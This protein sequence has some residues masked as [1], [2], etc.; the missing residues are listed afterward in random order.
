MGNIIVEKLQSIGAKLEYIRILSCSETGFTARLLFR[1]IGA[2]AF[3]TENHL[4][5][6][7]RLV[8]MG[9]NDGGR[10]SVDIGC[11]W[12]QLPMYQNVSVLPNQAVY[13]DVDVDLSRAGGI[14]HLAQKNRYGS[15]IQD[16]Y[17]LFGSTS[18][19]L[20]GTDYMKSRANRWLIT[21]A[22]V[23]YNVSLGRDV[24]WTDWPPAGS[25][26]LCK[27][28]FKRKGFFGNAYIDSFKNLVKADYANQAE[29][30]AIKVVPVN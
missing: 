3:E 10:K 15:D 17:S 5:S 1:N 14:F 18:I 8:L 9:G 2:G 23:P 24:G 30:N 21:L 26:W 7:L 16:V 6:G 4:I 27:L 13:F 25:F 28:F 29:R 11:L 20:L 12:I 19:D 22:Y